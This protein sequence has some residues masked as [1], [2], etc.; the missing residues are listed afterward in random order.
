MLRH[1]LVLNNVILSEARVSILFESRI[2]F[3][4]TI[5]RYHHIFFPF[6]HIH[7]F[8]FCLHFPFHGPLPEENSVDNEVQHS[9]DE[10]HGPHDLVHGPDPDGGH[11]KPTHEAPHSSACREKKITQSCYSKCQLLKKIGSIGKSAKDF[12]VEKL[13]T[14]LF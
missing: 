9:G 12:R 2:G 4:Q 6:R 3:T 8:P 7:C 5:C 11:D 13:I 14:T 10:G 1:S